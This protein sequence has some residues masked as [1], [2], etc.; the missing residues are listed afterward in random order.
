MS[1]VTIQLPEEHAL[2]LKERAAKTGRTPDEIVREQIEE[3]MAKVP[4]KASPG[5]NMAL[6]RTMIAPGK[7]W[8]TASSPRPRARM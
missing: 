6:G 8:R 2:W 7:A 3:A 4:N 5:P 1:T